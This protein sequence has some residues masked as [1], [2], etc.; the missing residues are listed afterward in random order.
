MCA[1]RRAYG[2]RHGA[3]GQ[4]ITTELRDAARRI[5]W[6]WKLLLVSAGLGIL[7]PMF[8]LSGGRPTYSVSTR[9]LV[10]P[11]AEASEAAAIADTV[12]AIVTSPSQLDSALQSTAVDV[13]PGSFSGGVSVGRVGESGVVY[14]T[15]TSGDPEVAAMVANAL[16]ENVS[17][18]V[19]AGRAG[20]AEA[21]VIEPADPS[22]ASEHAPLRSQDLVLGAVLGLV[23]GLAIAAVT[24]ALNPTLVGREA[25]AVQLGAPV[26]GSM[27]PRP[28]GESRSVQWIRWRLGAQA[29]RVGVATIE[30]AAV[31]RRIDLYPISAAL[32]T[33]GSAPNGSATNGSGPS[34][35][36]GNGSSNGHP[37]KLQVGILDASSIFPG[38]SAGLVIVTPA[39]V[40]KATFEATQ[41][42]IRITGWPAIGAI[43]YP[44]FRSVRL[45]VGG[46][47]HAIVPASRKV[48]AQIAKLVAGVFR[49]TSSWL[50]PEPAEELRADPVPAEISGEAT[51]DD[52]GAELSEDAD[53]TAGRS[54]ELW[55]RSS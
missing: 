54:P 15:V 19:N 38:G 11:T 29:S 48:A 40:K 18:L 34:P 55:A 36:A 52:P 45:A 24:E 51:P 9:F 8:L 25:I 43:V 46:F 30:L 26:L 23:I 41:E 50:R 22:A 3:T 53:P 14:L 39:T 49:T 10:D 21:I 31:D 35:E 32:V 7:L 13:D 4:E 12:A 1:T 44:R 5:L 33:N 16:R 47:A 37:F 6:H 20:S 42:L 28:R 27:S 2:G 17:A